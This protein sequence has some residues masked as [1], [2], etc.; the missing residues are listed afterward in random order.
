[1][2]DIKRE[3]LHVFHRHKAMQDKAGMVIS[4]ALHRADLLVV[5]SKLLQPGTVYDP[6]TF[7]DD[8][9][10]ITENSVE[11]TAT[12]KICITCLQEIARNTGPS[13]QDAMHPEGAA[14]NTTDRPVFTYETLATLANVNAKGLRDIISKLKVSGFCG[15]QQTGWRSAFQLTGVLSLPDTEEAGLLRNVIARPLTKKEI[16]QGNHKGALVLMR[17]RLNGRIWQQRFIKTVGSLADTT[18]LSRKLATEERLK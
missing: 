11:L 4:P 10:G 5:Q 18:G 8:R 1:M 16:E 13:F 3:L 12:L 17:C 9:Q 14:E 2:H 15:V 7:W 6:E